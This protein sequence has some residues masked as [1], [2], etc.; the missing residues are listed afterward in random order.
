M[1]PSLRF[2]IAEK[3]PIPAIP[4]ISLH[5]LFLCCSKVKRFRCRAIHSRQSQGPAE[6][7]WA[8]R[9]ASHVQPSLIL[10][11]GLVGIYENVGIP[12]FTL[13]LRHCNFL[14]PTML[15]AYRIRLDGKDQ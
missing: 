12:V 6:I 3:R 4:A 2:G 5:C 7:P 15:S 9:R 13:R 10:L 11:M 14:M 1:D 8:R